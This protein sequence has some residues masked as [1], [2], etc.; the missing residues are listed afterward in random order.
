MTSQGSKRSVDADDSATAKIRRRVSFKRPPDES[1]VSTDDSVAKR[2]KTL[3]TLTTDVAVNSL[4]R[5]VSDETS[6]DDGVDCTIVDDLTRDPIAVQAGKDKEL[7]SLL[8]DGVYTEVDEKS[9]K[10]KK[11]IN[12]RWVLVPKV[13]RVK[14]RLVAK[15]FKTDKLAM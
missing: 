4:I 12:T 8:E 11:V 6:N 5:A 14:A 13:G 3:A 2:T 1:Y 15:D 9:C 10:G 7:A